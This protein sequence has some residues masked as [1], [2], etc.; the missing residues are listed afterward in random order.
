MH[1][2]IYINIFVHIYLNLSIYISV[3]ISM[4]IYVCSH[5]LFCIQNNATHGGE[6]G[7]V[8]PDCAGKERRGSFQPNV[9]ALG[10]PAR[11]VAHVDPALAHLL[12]G[13]APVSGQPRYI[14]VRWLLVDM[15][16][17]TFIY[18]Y[19]HIHTYIYIHIYTYIYTC[20]NTHTNT[21]L[22]K[23]TYIYIHIHIYIYFLTYI[24]AYIH[25]HM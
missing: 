5:H 1:I 10:L 8:G 6:G 7:D 13:L 15:Y 21:H 14:T 19:I 16:K 17:H 23:Y 3:S 25:I 22:Y 24:H 2:Y 18:I 9:E 12:L 20:T 11:L 4:Y